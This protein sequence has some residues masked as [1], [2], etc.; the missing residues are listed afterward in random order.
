MATIVCDRCNESKE[1]L[2]APPTGGELGKTI[3][4]RICSDCW[5]A[6]R[7][8]SAQLINHYGLNLGAPDHRKQLRGAMKEFL[9]LED[10]SAKP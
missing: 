3:V 8:T 10:A 4:E 1:S 6:W 2:A 5:G 7:E 9:G